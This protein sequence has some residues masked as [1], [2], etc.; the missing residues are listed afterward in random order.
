[1]DAFR[2]M[3]YDAV[4]VGISEMMMQQGQYEALEKIKASG[5]PVLTLNVKYRGK[6][7]RERPIVFERKGL[8][9]AVFSILLPASLPEALSKEWEIEDPEDVIEGA[10]SFARG[11]A[12]L[13][14]GI[15]TGELSHVRGLVERHDGMHMVVVSQHAEKLHEP[16]KIKDSLLFSTGDMGQY[17]GRLDAER[18]NGKWVFRGEL[19]PL[20]RDMEA[21]P[22]M[23]K[24]YDR[25]KKRVLEMASEGEEEFQMKT[26]GSIHPL[27][28]AAD[29]RSCHD[30]VYDRWNRTVHAVAMKALV[31]KDEQYNPECVA[32]H[33]TG[34]KTGGFVSLD[35]TPKYS[36]IQCAACHGR[37]EGHM[38]FYAFEGE[39]AGLEEPF[40][41]P[42]TEK[43]CLICHTPKR[44]SDFY[45]ERDR[46]LVH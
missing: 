3:R 1:M 25:Y 32:C 45:F 17:L 24:V 22:A 14:I 21:D 15:L 4:T 11:N 34:Y 26:A 7:L 30:E 36:N 23:G 40:L 35:S 5:I 33:T 39:T 18:R 37:M 44:D 42:V 43:T 29:C 38:D 16:V 31:A 28:L 12:D 8:K 27:P 41:S 19:I 13:V 46:Q 9:V 20:T 2:E 10:L 6:R